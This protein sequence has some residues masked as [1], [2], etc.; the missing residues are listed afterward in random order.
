AGALPGQRSRGREHLSHAGTAAWPL[1]ADH[2]DLAFPVGALLDR[3]E[4]V[5][6]AVKAAGWTGKFQVRHARDFHDRPFWCEITLQADDASR[7]GNRP[8]GGPHHILMR[9]PLH[10]F[11]VLCDRASGDC[12][13]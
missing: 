12:Q 1:I 4:S 7:G 10:A 5:L 3:L 6:L 11:E 2:D 9:V 8:V 13:T